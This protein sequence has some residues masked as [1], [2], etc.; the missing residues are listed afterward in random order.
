MEALFD[1]LIFT[2]YLEPLWS[3]LISQ[4][5]RLLFGVRRK[6]EEAELGSLTQLIKEADEC[7]LSLR[8]SGHGY[9]NFHYHSMHT[10]CILCTPVILASL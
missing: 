3:F 9:C 7:L 4:A 10:R 6:K 2:E 8:E 1:W 5:M